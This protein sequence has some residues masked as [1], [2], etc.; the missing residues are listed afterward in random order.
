MHT[1]VHTCHTHNF[2]LLLGKLSELEFVKRRKEGMV[3]ARSVAFFLL[4]NNNA[5]S[6]YQIDRSCYHERV[7]V[8]FEPFYLPLAF[9]T[10]FFWCRMLWWWWHD[11][12]FYLMLCVCVVSSTLS[13]TFLTSLVLFEMIF[14]DEKVCPLYMLKYYSDYLKQICIKESAPN[15]VKIERCILLFYYLY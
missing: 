11:V 6:V 13:F 4:H 3:K 9:N 15:K 10:K 7:H 2:F 8:A 5:P 12:L 14:V 1:H